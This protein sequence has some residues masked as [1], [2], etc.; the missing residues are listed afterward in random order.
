MDAS[1]MFH[2]CLI[3]LMRGV[4][5]HPTARNW[6]APDTCDAARVLPAAHLRGPVVDTSFDVRPAQRPQ[7]D[8]SLKFTAP[9]DPKI[10]KGHHIPHLNTLEP[11]CLGH[12]MALDFLEWS[13]WFKWF[14]SWFGQIG[15]WKTP[16]AFYWAPTSSTGPSAQCRSSPSRKNSKKVL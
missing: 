4:S 13:P 12:L 11:W 8:S 6:A 2:P 9:N 16:T 5:R 15:T 1:T 3:F 10:S 14:H 7:V